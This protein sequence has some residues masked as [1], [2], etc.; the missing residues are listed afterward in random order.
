M[1]RSS[2]Q[3]RVISKGKKPPE[4]GVTKGKMP[5]KTE[6]QKLLEGWPPKLGKKGK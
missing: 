2:R 1:R 5:Q 6:F 4:S 3:P